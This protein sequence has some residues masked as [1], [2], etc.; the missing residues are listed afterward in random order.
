MKKHY[1]IILLITICLCGCK[2]SCK[3]FIHNKSN[4]YGVDVSHYQNAIQDIN[5]QNVAKNST[6]KIE[7]AYIRSTMGRDGVDKAYKYN[8]RQNWQK[9]I[10]KK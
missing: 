5:W 9:K 7:F 8:F 3:S 10:C 4:I 2:K 6:P 1:C